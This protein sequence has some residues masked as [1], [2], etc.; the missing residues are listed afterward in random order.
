MANGIKVDGVELYADWL[1]NGFR[2]TF[3]RGGLQSL[4]SY[5]GEDDVVPEASGRDPGVW[6]ADIREVALHGIVAGTSL[7]NFR[8]RADTLLGI[9]D[10]TDPVNIVAYPPH[11]GLST[12]EVATLSDCRP[13]SI[14]GPDASLL[15]YEGWEVTLR[16]V[17]IGSPPNWVIGS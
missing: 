6:I 14:E 13:Q 8:S 5:R 10:V 1:S 12:G 2:F 17:C 11:F 9:M 4:P 7:T 15:W 3:I 16:F